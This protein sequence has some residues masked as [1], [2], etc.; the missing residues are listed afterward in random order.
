MGLLRTPLLLTFACAL[1]DEDEDIPDSRAGLYERILNLL[2]DDYHRRGERQ[3]STKIQNLSLKDRADL[4]RVLGDIALS[5]AEHPDGWK[6]RMLA[7][8]IF[9]VIS[10]AKGES[11]VDAL[12]AAVQSGILI[13]SGINRLGGAPAYYFIHRTVAEYLVA[14]NL[15]HKKGIRWQELLERHLWFD[16]DWD[17]VLS[18]IGEFQVAHSAY[19]SA[20]LAMDPDIL[21]CGLAV[22]TR[23]VQRASVSAELAGAVAARWM[24]LWERGHPTAPY[25]LE[26]IAPKL[27]PRLIAKV[28][29][30]L[31]SDEHS[32]PSAALRLLAENGTEEAAQAIMDFFEDAKL[33]EESRFSG[34]IAASVLKGEGALQRRMAVL[35]SPTAAT[36]VRQAIA[37]QFKQASGEAVALG[38]AE[39]VGD[40]T[41][42]SWARFTASLL[43]GDGAGNKGVDAL[44]EALR[45]PNFDQEARGEA[46]RALRDQGGA[47][48]NRALLDLLEDS[49]VD[50]WARWMSALMLAGCGGAAPK[51][52]VLDLFRDPTT[53][54]WVRWSAA[55]S[56]QDGDLSANIEQGLVEVLH[57]PSSSM[58]ARWSAAFAL[59]ARGEEEAD[60]ALIEVLRDPQ[61]PSWIKAE[62]ARQLGGRGGSGGARALVEIVRTPTIDHS[63]RQNAA[64]ALREHD[65]EETRRALV[66]LLHDADIEYRMFELIITAL[67]GRQMEEVRRVLINIVSDPD[68]LSSPDH[69][70]AIRYL[71]SLGGVEGEP[72]LI[73]VLSSAGTH[74]RVRMETAMAAGGR[75][76]KPAD[77]I[78][79]EVLCDPASSS[80][81]RI[82]AI[83]VLGRHGGEREN[84]VLIEILLTATADRDLRAK[85]A[86]LL[87][88]KEGRDVAAALGQCLW[89]PGISRTAAEALSFSSPLAVIQALETA[90]LR[91][92]QTR[93]RNSQDVPLSFAILSDLIPMGWASSDWPLPQR[94]AVLTLLGTVTRIVEEDQSSSSR[95]S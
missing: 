42:D 24:F 89:V 36:W 48:A 43:L 63:V 92:K 47:R 79:F 2:L 10:S 86:K 34:A 40:P 76:L 69:I 55:Q 18:L 45:D 51:I 22:A 41:T 33:S 59:D 73:R 27:P 58:W 31:R 7:D 38:L 72:A 95:Q 90:V 49:T 91:A 37:E 11:E 21:H 17:E 1:A 56:L 25:Q 3:A 29:A 93:V 80:R 82:R 81:D 46:A 84:A 64:R 75:G 70:W 61:A 62:T 4:L 83:E 14:K 6:D 85:A 53:P 30:K 54:F 39:V 50:P 26:L 52:R 19:L 74:P 28:I 16:K 9:D 20:L 71:A 65:Q 68:T 8:E 87:G 66:N 15:A 12:R 94:Q 44:I 78:L 13:P 60:R 35:R 5:F 32:S 88:G 77:D 23:V 67:A 57:N